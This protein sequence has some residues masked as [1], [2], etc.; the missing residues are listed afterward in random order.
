MRRMSDGWHGWGTTLTVNISN[1]LGSHIKDQGIHQRNV[2]A[3]SS[4]IGYLMR[5]DIIKQN[6]YTHKS[7]KVL[8]AF[9]SCKSGSKN[10]PVALP[11]HCYSFIQNRGDFITQSSLTMLP[12]RFHSNPPLHLFFSFF[13]TVIYKTIKIERRTKYYLQMRSE[14]RQ[15]GYWSTRLQIRI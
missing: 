2:V 8:C 15:E 11:S 12:L 9:F 5:Q 13:N 7:Q 6:T 10:A 3:R 1:G 14:F 4:F